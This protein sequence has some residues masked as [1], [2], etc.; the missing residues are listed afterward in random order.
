MP[1]KVEIDDRVVR[2]RLETMPKRL[3]DALYRAVDADRLKLE[4][5]IKADKLSGQVLHVI[6][7]DLRASIH[8]D[9]DDQGNQIYGRAFSSGDV[10]YAAIH[11]YG[12]DI[13]PKTAKALVF[14]IDGKLIFS[15]HVHM[16]ER[17]YMRSSL[18][19]MSAQIQADLERAVKGEAAKP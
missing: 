12:G 16:P 18:R 13:Y 4:T 19:D 14:E 8:S 15:R 10:K 9:V 2:L 17:S 1:F 11:E 5:Y 7:S 6:S 3:H